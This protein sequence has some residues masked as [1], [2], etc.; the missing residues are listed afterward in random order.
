MYT[1][2]YLITDL[3]TAGRA[4]HE[5]SLIFEFDEFSMFGGIDSFSSRGRNHKE[6]ECAPF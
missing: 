2:D 4:S 1:Y 5:I 3:R 6:M